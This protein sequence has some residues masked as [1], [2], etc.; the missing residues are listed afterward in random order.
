MRGQADVADLLIDHGADLG[1]ADL[2]GRTP[3]HLAATPQ[4]VK[5]LLSRGAK[6][7]LRDHAGREPLH[8]VR[9]EGGAQALVQAGAALEARA[10]DG[11]RPIDMMI[12]ADEDQELLLCFPTTALVRMRGDEARL[13]LELMSVSPETLGPVEVRATT[14]AARVTPAVQAQ[15]FP[16]QVVTLALILTRNAEVEPADHALDLELLAAGRVL[17]RF[18]LRLDTR[19]ELTPEDQGMIPVAAVSLRQD[20]GVWQYLA[21]ASAPL[22]LLLLWWVTRSR[23]QLP[24]P[25]TTPGQT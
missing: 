9:S 19:R 14:H 3:L 8:L 23:R 25:A 20:P 17:T 21:Y 2:Y 5:L 4:M 12:T 1:A 11:R 10:R 15:L 6:V 7:E 16:G 13:G 18:S 22:V 24:P